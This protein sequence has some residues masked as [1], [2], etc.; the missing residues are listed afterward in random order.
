MKASVDGYPGSNFMACSSLGAANEVYHAYTSLSLRGVNPLYTAMTTTAECSP[1]IAS[2][3]DPSSKPAA[4]GSR[5][6]KR[7]GHRSMQPFVLDESVAAL[8][9][10]ECYWVAWA[11]VRPGVFFGM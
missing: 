6:D 9:G 3:P 4:S 7:T 2:I 11:A 1:S 10:H 5:S 8:A